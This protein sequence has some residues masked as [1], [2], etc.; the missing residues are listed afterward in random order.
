MK[1]LTEEDSADERASED[2]DPNE[3]RAHTISINTQSSIH[4]EGLDRQDTQKQ[5]DQ[6]CNSAE[7]RID[8]QSSISHQKKQCARRIVSSHPRNTVLARKRPETQ[9]CY[10]NREVE[11]HRYLGITWTCQVCTRQLELSK[12][13]PAMCHLTLNHP[14]KVE[15]QEQKAFVI[16]PGSERTDQFYL[17][18][19]PTWKPVKWPTEE[20]ARSEPRQDSTEDDG[21][22]SPWT[23]GCRMSTLARRGRWGRLSYQKDEVSHHFAGLIHNFLSLSGSRIPCLPSFCSCSSVNFLFGTDSGF[24][25]SGTPPKPSDGGSPQNQSCNGSLYVLVTLGA[26]LRSPK[27]LALLSPHSLWI[28]LGLHS[29]STLPR[30][31]CFRELVPTPALTVHGR[32][33]GP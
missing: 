3:T 11:E 16:F 18:R 14:V 9:E 4:A 31:I 29:R 19:L 22:A 28:L 7:S 1:K 5:R 13:W 6:E 26:V 2:T 15:M 32:R 20:A 21:P 8:H 25:N 23:L 30:C 27:R 24:M 10:S 17:Q 12:L 33:S